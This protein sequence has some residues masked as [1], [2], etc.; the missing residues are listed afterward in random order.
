MILRITVGLVFALGVL[1]ADDLPKSESRLI[2]LNVIAV[3]NQ[4]QPVNDLTSDDFLVSDAGKPQNI[5]FFRHNDGKLLRTPSLG[6][7]DFS[8]RGS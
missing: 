6:P 8:N 1:P 4:G 3:D 7:N 2:D 5:S